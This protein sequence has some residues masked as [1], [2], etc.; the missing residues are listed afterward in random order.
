MATTTGMATDTDTTT[1]GT[2]ITA[3]TTD[4]HRR[5]VAAGIGL[6][7]LLAGAACD[8][9]PTSARDLADAAGVENPVGDR[10]AEEV[11]TAVPRAGIQVELANLRNAIL[12]HQ[13]FHGSPPPSLDA[14]ESV[15]RLQF[16][17]EYDYDPATGTVKSRT[18]PDL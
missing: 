9:E 6:G 1:Q 16:P 12:T 18:F 10:I 15:P 13:R 11:T 5:R 4:R 17:D 3:T 8:R 2:I 7:L 14:L